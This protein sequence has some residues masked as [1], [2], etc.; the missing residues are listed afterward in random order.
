MAIQGPRPCPLI[1]NFPVKLREFNLMKKSTI[2]LVPAVGASM[3]VSE[4]HLIVEKKNRKIR[5][6]MVLYLKIGVNSDADQ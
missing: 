1:R 5:G 4:K 2:R 6:G 3:P